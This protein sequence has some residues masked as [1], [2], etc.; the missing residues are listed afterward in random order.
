MPLE[1]TPNV[2]NLRAMRWLFATSACVCAE[3]NAAIEFGGYIQSAGKVQ[4]VLFD[5][6]TGKSSPFLRVGDAFLGYKV[7]SVSNDILTI[8]KDG[9]TSQLHLKAD[10]VKSGSSPAHSV[11]QVWKVTIHADGKIVLSVDGRA[12]FDGEPISY[13]ELDATFR[14]L[15]ARTRAPLFLALQQ[16]LAGTKESLE[17]SKLVVDMLKHRGPQKWT[18]LIL[19]VQ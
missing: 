15:S 4:V 11:K 3:V 19:P 18:I 16:P 17:A 8:E 14:Q 10:A 9:V 7:V 5:S 13:E 12:V 1:V 2:P 6:A